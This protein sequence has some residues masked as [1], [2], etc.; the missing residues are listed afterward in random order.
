MRKFICIL[1]AALLAVLCCS[2]G[3]NIKSEEDNKRITKDLE[4]CQIFS[5]DVKNEK[6]CRI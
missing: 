3:S 4:K 2:C 5:E 1:L 6:N